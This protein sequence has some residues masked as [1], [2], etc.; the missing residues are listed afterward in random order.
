MIE[1][2]KMIETVST[3]IKLTISNDSI[4]FESL[5]EDNLEAKTS[6]MIE[7]GIKNNFTF[8]VNSRYILDFLHQVVSDKFELNLNEPNLPFLLKDNDFIT[9][10][11][12]IVL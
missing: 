5:A 7:N 12:P 2:I 1:A 11:M 3:D 8:A 6:I 10:I 9:V 4:L